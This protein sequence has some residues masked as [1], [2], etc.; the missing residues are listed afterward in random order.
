MTS[1][2]APAIDNGQ[3][4]HQIEVADKNLTFRSVR[5]DDLTPTGAQLAAAAGFKPAQNAVVLQFLE[6]G[7]LEDIR[8]EETVDLKHNEGRFI[9][10]ESDRQY[11]LTID[12]QRF[13]WPCNIITGATIRKLGS[14]P[15]EKDLYLEREDVADQRIEANKMVDLDEPGVES[16]KSRKKPTWQVKVQGIL[17]T[18]STPEVK[19]RDALAL[20]GLDLTQSWHVYLKMAG[21]PVTEIT[22]DTMVDLR[23]EGIEKITAKPRDVNNGEALPAPRRDFDLL[24]V[25]VKYL[26]HLGSRWE[27]INE[28][29]HRWL[30]IHGYAVPDGYTVTNVALA[31]EIPGTYP[32]SQIDMF[33]T[34]P[35]LARSN[36]V[37]I[38]ATEASMVIGGLTYGRWSRHRGAGSLWNPAIDN[39]VTH[40]ALVDASIAKEVGQ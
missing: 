38:P 17:L 33:Y 8:P 6:N 26:D 19:A 35:R 13:P 27:T 2:N 3:S 29:G 20:A 24:P 18:F 4:R 32:A 9:I 7:L 39:V 30:L 23:G 14:I 16:F 36:G 1:V 28:G 21:S 12:G 15:A 11:L 31:L 37:G 5:I 10:V 34:Y 40:L 25:D 22:L